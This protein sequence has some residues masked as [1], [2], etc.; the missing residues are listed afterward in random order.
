M[1]INT[2]YK[3]EQFKFIKKSCFHTCNPVKEIGFSRE[4]HKFKQR[5]TFAKFPASNMDTEKGWDRM[6]ITVL[7]SK[8]S[9]S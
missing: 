9:L 1:N 8:W 4:N 3:V 7:C 6:G 5:A 2:M